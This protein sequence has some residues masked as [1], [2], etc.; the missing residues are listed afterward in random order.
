MLRTLTLSS[1]LGM[2]VPAF[3]QQEL[4]V[5]SFEGAEVLFDVNTSDVGSGVGANTWLVNDV[6]TRWKWNCGLPRL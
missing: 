6:F 2:L 4:F 1:V 3:G 5:E